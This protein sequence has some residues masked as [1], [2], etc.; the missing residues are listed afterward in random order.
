M[1]KRKVV[2]AVSA[3]A[4]ALSGV[5]IPTNVFA[6]DNVVVSPEEDTE[7]AVEAPVDEVDIDV[8]TEVDNK[9]TEGTFATAPAADEL[10]DGYVAYRIWDEKQADYAY[11]VMAA[12]E[13]GTLAAEATL[14]AGEYIDMEGLPEDYVGGWDVSVNGNEGVAD[15]IKLYG[16]IGRIYVDTTRVSAAEAGVAHVAIRPAEGAVV[17]KE[18]DAIEFGIDVTLVPGIKSGNNGV[19]WVTFTDTVKEDGE[20][21]IRKIDTLPGAAIM[22]EPKLKVAYDISVV[23]SDGAEVM[24]NENEIYVS[25]QLEGEIDRA[26]KYYQLAYVKDGVITEYIDPLPGRGVTETYIVN[27]KT[28]HLSSYGVLASDEPFESAEAK[29]VALR[30]GGATGAGAGGAADASTP[31]TGAMTM[32]EEAGKLDTTAL[33]ATV[34][35]MTLATVGME[36]VLWKKRQNGKMLQ[37][38]QEVGLDASIMQ[39]WEGT[40]MQD[41]SEE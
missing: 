34:T 2:S 5:V 17:A 11:K 3:I 12:A 14:S 15:L 8:A 23:K 28:T 1:T 21:A 6:T 32:V 33:V 10:A 41:L 40:T 37:L 31:E 16:D 27:F 22:A 19:V 20:L 18:G 4:L 26:Y 39:D 9:V 35:V 7:T 29:N 13:F 24:V 36:I 30:T 38:P 25:L